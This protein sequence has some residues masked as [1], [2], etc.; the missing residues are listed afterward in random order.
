MLCSSC[1]VHVRRDFP[2]CLRCGTP[3]R[4]ARASDFAAPQL[5]RAD[6]PAVSLTRPRTTIGRD[7]DCD[8]VLDD[9]SVS[10]RHATV[11]RGRAGF[12]VE[13]L[14]SLNGTT[15]DGQRAGARGI[16]VRDGAHLTVGDV[17]L[18]FVQPRTTMVGGRT[19][20]R[21]T[22]HTVLGSVTDDEAPTATEPLT[23]RPRRRSGWALKQVPGSTRAWV[24]RNTRTGQYLE[25]DDRDVFL[26]NQL[27]DDVA[28][29]DLLFAYAEQYGELALPRIERTL[30]AFAAIDLVR[31]LPGQRTTDQSSL[32]RRV[33]R[34]VLTALL[35][36]QVSI[37][38]LDGA[39]GRLYQAV[40]WRCFT[41]TGVVLLWLVIL[42]G[43]VAFARA[44][45]RER[46]FSLHG[47]GLSGALVVGAG[48][49]LALAVHET[50]HGLAV[51]S[52]G[53]RVNRGGFMIM[54]A[55]PFAF[56]DTSDM[57][58]GSRW[59][60]VVVALSGPMS[61]AAIA[62]VA[63]AGA[64]W[65]PAGVA[66]ALLF[67]LAF[68]LY[69]NTLYNFN[70]LMPLDG[71]Q[72]LVDALRIPRLR[73]QAIAYFVRGL[74]HDLRARRRPG[75]VQLGLLVY[76]LAS[77]VSLVAM[78]ALA[79]VAWNGRLGPLVRRAVP[80]PWDL[81]VLAAAIVL[82]TLPIWVRLA[83][84]AARLARRPTREAVAHAEPAEV[85]A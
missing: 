45:H 48:Y 78:S 55:M 3:R 61:T 19:E 5:V 25:L 84:A 67:Q 12:T 64:A 70:P 63:A 71:Y 1:R 27:A 75:L 77:C 53:R 34:A 18:R 38:G 43:L 47:A 9:P 7:P 65:L 62:G 37:R 41:R 10:R 28:V 79:L 14:G 49:L 39:L 66:P 8:V 44:T 58:F 24:L 68:G 40:G 31:G 4:G 6:G 29:R 22:E 69:M 33:G 85:I 15:V 16:P 21:G 32:A 59:S 56:M 42:G 74:W 82:V 80:A 30:R 17:A 2:Y 36:L 23:V 54:M 52:Y 57:W 11:V 60:R 51:K 83:K 20:F 26:W 50:A 76:G 46:L 35:R 73:E 13:D 81:V 72:A